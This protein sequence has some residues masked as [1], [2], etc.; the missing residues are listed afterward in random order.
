[1]AAQQFFKSKKDAAALE[2]SQRHCLTLSIKQDKAGH[3]VP[4]VL[5][6]PWEAQIPSVPEHR[7]LMQW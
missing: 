3:S 5:L 1:M 2:Q 7:Q 4:E 6:T